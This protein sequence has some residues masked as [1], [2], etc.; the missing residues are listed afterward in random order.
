MY[1]KRE[2]KRRKKNTILEFMFLTVHSKETWKIAQTFFFMKRHF[3]K[4]HECFCKGDS[5]RYVAEK[6]SPS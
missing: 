6:F 2:V 5:R 4:L 1:A 3:M